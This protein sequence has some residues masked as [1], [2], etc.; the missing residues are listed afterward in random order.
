MFEI[1]LDEINLEWPVASRYVLRRVEGSLGRSNLAIYPADDATF[2]L[3]RPLEQNPSL[4]AEFAA[5]DDTKQSCL[6]FAHK[7]GLLRI[8][9]PPK[10][11]V[12]SHPLESL[13]QWKSDIRSI[14]D[15]ISLCEIGRRR[16]AEA[17]RQFGNKDKRLWGFETYLSMKSPNSPPSLDVRCQSLFAAIQFQAVL[18]ILG[19]RNNVQCLECSRW[20]PIGAGARRSQ[21]KFCSTRCKDSYH[22]RLKAEAKRGHHA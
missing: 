9:K 3:H 16:P 21:S 14:R 1:N 15:T 18:S 5:L 13:T 11:I 19:G 10:V 7:Y 17:F 4:Y 8:S 2:T 22:N 20:F 12:D 6:Q